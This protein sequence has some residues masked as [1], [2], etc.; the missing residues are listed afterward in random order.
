MS[1]AHTAERA[2]RARRRSA[3]AGG[4]LA[5]G[6]LEWGKLECLAPANLK[7]DFNSTGG[8]TQKHRALARWTIFPPPPSRWPPTA[9][10][11]HV[12][13]S[14]SQPCS[15]AHCR[16]SRWPALAA[17]KHVSLFHS[18]P[19][20][21]AHCSNA[22][23]P[24]A[25]AAEH[26]SL[27]HSQPCSR[28]HCSNARWPLAAAAEHVQLPLAAVLSR[29]LQHLQ[30]ASPSCIGARVAVPLAATLAQ[31]RDRTD[32][33]S[34]RRQRAQLDLLPRGK[35]GRAEAGK[36]PRPGSELARAQHRRVRRAR[37][38]GNRV[39]KGAARHAH[40]QRVLR[41]DERADARE[42]VG[43]QPHDCVRALGARARRRAPRQHQR[44][45]ARS[46]SGAVAR[47][48]RLTRRPPPSCD[49][50]SSPS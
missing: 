16:T 3:V 2:P 39:R 47:A 5:L 37:R 42:H 32:A 44:A 11:E 23:W 30:V 40:A 38:C 22:R 17:Q 20:S 15:R 36:I 8:G 28:A 4:E 7:S 12:L 18:Q 25:A 43:G 33:P 21:C 45:D 24:L 34:P 14:H 31:P 26:V 48:A 10:P 9:A 13:L 46:A 27:F 6:A 29:P 1:D 50:R 35:R 49:A 41:P 19:C